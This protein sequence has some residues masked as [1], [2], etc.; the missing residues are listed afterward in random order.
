MCEGI[1]YLLTISITVPFIENSPYAIKNSFTFVEKIKGLVLEPNDKMVSFDAAA[2]FPSVPIKDCLDHILNLLKYDNDLP[3]RT[4]LSPDEIVD[5][6]SLCL[7]TSDFIYNDRHHS[8]KD[9]GPIGLSL[10]VTV[11]QIWMIYTMENTIPIAT[12]KGLAIPRHLSIY[13]DKFLGMARPFSVAMG[14]AFSMV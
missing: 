4:K 1:F 7:S 12:E 13:I 11:S 14:M 9:S 2:L 5:L 10:M 8:T 3:K 6:A